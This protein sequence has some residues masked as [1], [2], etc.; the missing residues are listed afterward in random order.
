[1]LRRW[2]VS[3]TVHL[4]GQHIN[5][6]TQSVKFF[7]EMGLFILNVSELLPKLFDHRIKPI[8]L[9]IRRLFISICTFIDLGNLF[10]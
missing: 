9:F 1:L 7:A 6:L 3:Q 10:R 8:N 4:F 5:E 2:L